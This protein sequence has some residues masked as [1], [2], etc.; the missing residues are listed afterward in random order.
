MNMKYLLA[1]SVAAVSIGTAMADPK[2]TVFPHGIAGSSNVMTSA[3]AVQGTL[4]DTVAKAQGSV[5]QTD[6]N[7]P[8]GYAKL[9][10]SGHVTVPVTGSVAAAPAN[11]AGDTVSSIA[12]TAKNAQTLAAGS[13][14][15]SDIGL[16]N[17]VAPTD[18][19]AMMSAPVSGIV[20][21]GIMNFPIYPITSISIAAGGANYAVGDINVD[22]NG[23]VTK[24]S[25][26]DSYGGVTELTPVTTY[27]LD[28]NTSLQRPSTTSGSGYNLA[29]TF[30]YGSPVMSRNRAL[31]T[32][33]TTGFGYTNLNN[34]NLNFDG[35]DADSDLSALMYSLPENGV[36]NVNSSTNSIDVTKTGY[37]QP[38]NIIVNDYKNSGN[39]YGDGSI[40]VSL[41]QGI[42]HRRFVEKN[43][44]WVANDLFDYTFGYTGTAHPENQHNV[45]IT[46]TTGKDHLGNIVASHGNVTNLAGT[47]YSYG[48]DESGSYDIG[49]SFVNYRYGNN[50]QWGNITS[51]Q[52][53]NDNPFIFHNTQEWIAELDYSGWGEDGGPNKN[54]RNGLMLTGWQ[55]GGGYTVNWAPT[56]VYAVGDVIQV[57]VNGVLCSATVTVGG[58]SGTSA[59]NWSTAFANGESTLQTADPA[60]QPTITDGTVTWRY[61]GT[62]RLVIDN[63]MVLSYQPDAYN[64][65]DADLPKNWYG[66]RTPFV[67]H[68]FLKTDAVFDRAILD[69]A[70]AQW[71]LNKTA[72]WA[73][74]PKDTYVDLSSS[75]NDTSS[76]NVNLWG[77]DSSQSALT[78]KH[79]G[80][81]VFSV[82]TSGAVKANTLSL[83]GSL[84]LVAM[85][86]AQIL[87]LP[88]PTEGQK[89]FDSD[90]HEEVT[91]RCPTSSTCGWFPVQYGTALS[92]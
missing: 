39:Y 15:K 90:D 49:S 54:T 16:K 77:F 38:K 83:S 1:C 9:D 62:M 55:S 72:I 52:E 32:A 40:H 64:N 3:G 42:T 33:L 89:V 35:N 20:N 61:N 86:K 5:Q 82:S 14:Q 91:Y 25:G 63:G 50:W 45:W 11:A 74:V 48:N 6:A 56:H 66:N 51:V 12:D 69:F 18:A 23:Y 31:L 37:N 28:G 29:Y 70:N 47:F 4:S 36:Y 76:Y 57:S 78:L 22:G 34:Y 60:K 71:L 21:S 41:D 65:Q 88:T 59:P 10:G 19:N 53:L 79:N 73:R 24:V 81:T 27:T 43:L 8:N 46:T 85:T 80:S 26:V 67:F 87:A 13:V 44:K 2:P 92:N 84:Y 17:S 75:F 7:Q 58:T 68:S 30:V